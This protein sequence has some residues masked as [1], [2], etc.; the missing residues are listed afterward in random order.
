MRG[1]KNAYKILIG[2]PVGKIPIRGSGCEEN[3]KMHP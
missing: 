3:M 2:N 1:M